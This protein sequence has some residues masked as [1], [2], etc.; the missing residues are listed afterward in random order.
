MVEAQYATAA[1]K[2]IR[3]GLIK[4]AFGI[5]LKN[6]RLMPV[7]PIPNYMPAEVFGKMIVA[8]NDSMYGIAEIQVDNIWEIDS[9]SVLPAGKKH[10]VRS[11]FSLQKLAT[12][13]EFSSS[14]KTKNN[15]YTRSARY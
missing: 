4:E 3:E 10:W 7:F 6:V 12:Q 13:W 14:E 5:G 8:H 9:P 2:T 15:R 11:G 1:A